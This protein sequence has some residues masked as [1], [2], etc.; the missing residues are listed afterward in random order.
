MPLVAGVDS[1]TQS[2]KV[3]IRD[4]AT[5]ALVRQGRAPHPDG[6]EVDPRA[7]WDALRTAVAAAGGLADVA[8]VSV[9]GQQHGMVCLD[10]AGEVVRPALLWNDTRSADAAR[11]LIDEAGGGLA[12]RRFWAEAVGSVPVASF[13]GTKLRW[14]ARHE[15]ERADRVAAVCLPHDWLTWRLAG[16]PGLAALCT[17][18]GDA[19]GTGYWSP[20]TGEY[21][22]DLLEQAFGRVVA[23]PTVLGPAEAAGV[24]DPATLGGVTP[25]AGPGAGSGVGRSGAAPGG[26]VLGPGTGDNAAAALGVGA[27]PG[28]VVV[29]I[30]TS[31]TVFSVADVPAADPGGAVAGFADA[32]GRYLPLVCTLNAARVLDA[33]AALLRVG[34]DELTELALSAPPG[35]DGLVMVPYLEGERTPDRPLST[36]ALHGLTLRTATPA[37]LARAAVEGMLCALADGLDA[38]TAQGADARRVILVGGG[39]RSAAVRRIA[40][41]VFGRPVVVPPPGEYVADGAARQ[42][43]W[44]ALG[45]AAPP[46]WADAGIREY[47]AEP[48]PAVRERYAQARDRT[49]DRTSG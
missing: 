5:G 35:A 36:G 15:P 29:S 6:T 47:D 17:D 31:G 25:A 14:L 43:A 8:A 12:G 22:L 33:A 39:A 38:L 11:D 45:G 16:A 32:T 3:V 1:S 18:R 4:A 23:V 49:V 41:Q 21:R 46:Q 26:I 48:V 24:L 10:E 28:D 40:P 37:H 30:G 2:C 20:S 42:A 44:V 9:A 19:S 13:T 7:W 34:L 27:G